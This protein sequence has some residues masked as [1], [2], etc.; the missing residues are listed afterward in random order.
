VLLIGSHLLVGNNFRRESHLFV[1]IAV[2]TVSLYRS[3]V[4]AA[5]DKNSEIEEKRAE[6]EALK[7]KYADL[8]LELQQKQQAQR[9]AEE[10][11]LKNQEKSLQRIGELKSQLQTERR[12]KNEAVAKT[13]LENDKLRDQIADLRFEMQESGGNFDGNANAGKSPALFSPTPERSQGPR[14]ITP[15]TPEP[16]LRAT[17]NNENVYSI[18]LSG[19]K[20]IRSLV[21]EAGGRNGLKKKIQQLRSP[22]AAHQQAATII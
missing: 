19:K 18:S 4:E 7:Q 13:K 17:N 12:N 1:F 11:I 15:S 9:S 8:E 20:T 5:R 3:A 22:R 16:T 2:V 14:S 21:K 6:I 10:T